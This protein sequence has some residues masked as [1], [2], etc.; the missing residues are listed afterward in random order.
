MT[1]SVGLAG[2]AVQ[3]HI[4]PAIGEEGNQ[5]QGVPVFQ[6]FPFQQF[7]SQIEAPG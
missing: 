1:S 5:R 7:Q 4:G 3:G 6:L 2:A